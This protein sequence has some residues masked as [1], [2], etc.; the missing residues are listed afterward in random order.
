MPANVPGSFIAMVKPLG[1]AGMVI[2]LFSWVTYWLFAAMVSSRGARLDDD[3]EDLATPSSPPAQ[4]EPNILMAMHR[5][6]PLPV[7]I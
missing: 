4:Q 5:D 2:Q 3:L 1:A 7:K 6:A